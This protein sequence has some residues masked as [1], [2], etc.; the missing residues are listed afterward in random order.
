MRDFITVSA[1]LIAVAIYKLS[2]VDVKRIEFSA[3]FVYKRAGSISGHMVIAFISL[4][5]RLCQIEFR[6]IQDSLIEVS[7]EFSVERA[8]LSSYN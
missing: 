4:M 2:T 5:M 6:V 8:A 1:F 3:C 7:L